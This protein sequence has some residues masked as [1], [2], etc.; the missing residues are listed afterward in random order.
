[1]KQSVMNNA[2]ME[3]MPAVAR[4]ESFRAI[5]AEKGRI[6]AADFFPPQR[7]EAPSER[8]WPPRP[9]STASSAYS[10]TGS[11]LLLVFL[12][13]PHTYYGSPA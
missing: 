8:F 11:P 7:A 12:M 2:V 6:R 3:S 13:S 4:A 5:T 9:P 1:V 10:A